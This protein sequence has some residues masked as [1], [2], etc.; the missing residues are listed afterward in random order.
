MLLDGALA[1]IELPEL[2]EV[3]VRV[4]TTLLAEEAELGGAEEEDEAADE[5]DDEEEVAAEVVVLAVVVELLAITGAE[6]AATGAEVAA[7]EE[8]TALAC[9]WSTAVAAGVASVPAAGVVCAATDVVP[10]RLGTR[11]FVSSP[12]LMRTRASLNGRDPRSSVSSCS[13]RQEAVHS[14]VTGG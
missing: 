2:I 12:D 8:V 14:R 10:A 6:V 11:T 5:L 4:D 1:L 9:V 7:E 13:Q 3:E